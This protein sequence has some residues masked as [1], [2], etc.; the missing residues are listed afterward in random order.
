MNNFP[1]KAVGR[2]KA[3]P[4]E[5]QVEAIS[6]MTAYDDVQVFD[7]TCQEALIEAFWAL[8]T[9]PNAIEAQTLIRAMLMQKGLYDQFDCPDGRL[10]TYMDTV[11]FG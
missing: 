2:L 3:L 1:Y 5:E 6:D 4:T 11:I 7:M 10:T 9:D 8:D